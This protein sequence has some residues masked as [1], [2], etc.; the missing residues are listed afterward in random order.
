MIDSFIAWFRRNQ[1][2]IAWFLI[3]WLTL[4]GLHEIQRGDGV[5]ALIDF[6]LAYL[7]YRLMKG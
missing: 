4:A 3:G 7:N 1:Y 6:A 2:E 5:G